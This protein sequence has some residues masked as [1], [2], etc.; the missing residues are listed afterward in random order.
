MTSILPALAPLTES[1]VTDLGRQL[2]QSG[3]VSVDYARGVFTAVA[4][5]PAAMDPATWLPWLVGSDVPDKQS[6]REVIALLV[7]DAQSIAQCLELGEPWL[8]ASS[9][10]LAQFCKGFTRVTQ[11]DSDWQKAPEVFTKV[12]PI[13][14]QA[15]YLDIASIERF[16]PH[17]KGAQA[18]LAEEHTRLPER[19]LEVHQH[20]APARLI[21]QGRPV[22][23]EKVGRNEPC[24]CG[25]GRKHKKCCAH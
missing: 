16:A 7:R 9:E 17:G 18:W 13:A 25:S 12:L 15:G 21:R 11:F 1:E 23:S 22:T 4:S 5:G 3:G 8:P 2:S 24:P 10:S 14:V 19:L 6:L 20:F